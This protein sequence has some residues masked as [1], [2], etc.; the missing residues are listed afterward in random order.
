MEAPCADCSARGLASHHQ[1][2]G[3]E[4]TSFQINALVTKKL[5]KRSKETKQYWLL[6]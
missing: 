1:I 3:I 4:N 6:R 2:P 5:S